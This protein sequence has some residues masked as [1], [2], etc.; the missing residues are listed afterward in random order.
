MPAMALGA[1]FPLAAS[2]FPRGSG[3]PGRQWM[4]S[5]EGARPKGLLGSF[6]L[7][8]VREGPM[9]CF[10]LHGGEG[11]PPLHVTSQALP[12]SQGLTGREGPPGSKGA[13]GERVSA[14]SIEGGCSSVQG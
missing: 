10:P 6:G 4:A 5:T 2:L 12:P 3:P 8:L 1:G 11:A 13:P 9:A 14:S 7:S